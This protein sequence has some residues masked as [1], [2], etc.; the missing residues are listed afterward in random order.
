M[1]EEVQM[2]AE[3]RFAV[4]ELILAYGRAL[5]SR[6]AAAYAAVFAPDGIR[7]TGNGQRIQRGRAEIQAAVEGSFKTWKASVRHLATPSYI[8]GN[9]TRCAVRTY[10]QAC[11]QH[12]DGPIQIAAVDE[13]QDVCVKLE[14]RWYFQE[15]RI[16]TLLEDPSDPLRKG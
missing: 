15:R 5:D 8:E 3:D 11:V 14:G 12:A 16:T 1:S 7:V 13:Y 9:G 2:T 6:D 10:G 4:M